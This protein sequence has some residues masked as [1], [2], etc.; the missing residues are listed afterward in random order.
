MD[1]TTQYCLKQKLNSLKHP[2]H[3]LNRLDFGHISV[4]TACAKKTL[5]DMQISIIVDGDMNDAYKLTKRQA[6]ILLEVERLF[7]AQK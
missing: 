3:S 1:G 2:L 5:E 6:D 4:R 7:L